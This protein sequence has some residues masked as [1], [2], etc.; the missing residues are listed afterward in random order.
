MRTALP[1]IFRTRL[2]SALILISI[3][4]LFTDCKKGCGEQACLNNGECIDGSCRCKGRFSGANC[5]KE[6]PIGYEGN[7]CDLPMRDKFLRAWNARTASNAGS[8]KTFSMA[9]A[10]GAKV[11]EIV[12]KNVTGEGF[13]FNATM[14]GSTTFVIKDKYF[15]GHGYQEATGEGDLLGDKLTINLMIGSQNYFTEATAR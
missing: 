11:H 14:N 5:E 4:F 10:P 3:S 1:Q 8:S 9:F 2:F 7:N 15:D 12:I 6:C 13:S